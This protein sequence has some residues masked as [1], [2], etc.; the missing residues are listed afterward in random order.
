MGPRCNH[1][2]PSPDDVFCDREV[3]HDGPHRGHVSDDQLIFWSWG[4]PRRALIR[5]QRDDQDLWI[6]VDPTH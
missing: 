5:L 4:K 3:N 2:A 6:I 1:R